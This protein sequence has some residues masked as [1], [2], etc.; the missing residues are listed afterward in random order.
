MRRKERT[1]LQKLRLARRPPT[2]TELAQEMGYSQGHLSRFELG[3]VRE[4]TEA[5]LAQYIRS[6]K[7]LGIHTTRAEV[8]RALAE[9][10]P[11]RKRSEPRGRAA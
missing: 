8:L 4:P 9:S 5:F 6:M 2:L 10:H 7:K 3:L 1:P 11:G